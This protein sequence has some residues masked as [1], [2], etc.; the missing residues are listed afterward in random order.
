MLSFFN[1]LK[2]KPWERENIFLEKLSLLFIKVD[3]DKI[4][5]LLL[6]LSF[7]L[8]ILTMAISVLFGYPQIGPL[9]SIIV[10][11]GGWKIPRP[12]INYLVERRIRKYQG[13]MVDA[14]NLL[15]NGIEG[16]GFLLTKV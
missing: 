10:G 2:I 1:G 15:G 13:Q 6:F 7:G 11:I 14:L 3:P 4:T 12:F 16:R 5:Y 9:L 8:A